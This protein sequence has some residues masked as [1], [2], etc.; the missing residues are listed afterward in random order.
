[1]ANGGY[2]TSTS[3]AVIQV[4]NGNDTTTTIASS[5]NPAWVGASVTFTATVSNSATGTVSFYDGAT[6]IGTSTQTTG[7]R[8]YSTTTLEPGSH[9]ITAVYAGGGAYNPS[10]SPVLT[11]AIT[12]T[13]LHLISAVCARYTD[14]PANRWYTTTPP[15]DDTLGHASELNNSNPISAGDITGNTTAVNC[16]RVGGWT[17]NLSTGDMGGTTIPGQTTSYTTGAGG[18]VTVPLNATLFALANHPDGATALWVKETTQPD[19]AGFGSL[20][21]Y[22]NQLYADNLDTIYGVPVGTADVYCLVYNVQTL[23]LAKSANPATFSTL[24]ETITYTYTVTNTGGVTATPLALPTISDDKINGGTAFDC[25][26]GTLAYNA[27]RTCNATY[28][29]TQA[30]LDAGTVTNTAVAH[31]GT[32]TSNQAQA[33]VTRRPVLVITALPQ[34][35]TYGTEYTL[36]TTLGVGYT[37]TGLQ[38]GD[39]VTASPSPPSGGLPAN[40]PVGGV[41]DHAERGNRHGS[42]QVRH[43]VRD[44]HPY[45]RSPRH[46]DRCRSAVQD[47]RR[48]R[49]DPDLRYRLGLARG[50]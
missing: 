35:K 41:H 45:C 20:H 11:Q 42:R 38:A 36:D 33:T 2:L 37:V 24:D 10:T 5:A 6:L 18:M 7:N 46:H 15:A 40:A 1:M 19:W 12:A 13:Q 23:T 27:T 49:S 48:P 39:S 8:T 47:I 30:D 16:E 50:R 34:S 31:A 43:P 28:Q 44:G 14:V 17:F 9:S 22:S 3:P 29:I 21:C 26:T 4:V 32:V 25:G